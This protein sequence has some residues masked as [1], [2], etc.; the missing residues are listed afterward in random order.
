VGFAS[1]REKGGVAALR[2][3]LSRCEDAGALNGD[4]LALRDEAGALNGRPSERMSRFALGARDG[5]DRTRTGKEMET[6]D[7]DALGLETQQKSVLTSAPS[8]SEE[9]LRVMRALTFLGLTQ[10]SN[11]HVEAQRCGLLQRWDSSME[12]VIF[13]SQEWSS[14]DQPDHTGARLKCMQ[15][16]IRRMLA[17]T[18]PDVEPVLQDRFYLEG[19]G[20]S[21]K[22]WKH[23]AHR[24][25]ILSDCFSMR[26][27]TASAYELAARASTHLFIVCPPSVR[28]RDD[29]HSCDLASWLAQSWS[30]FQM[31]MV[32]VHHLERVPVVVVRGWHQHP[33]PFLL[34]AHRCESL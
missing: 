24:A 8:C 2:V 6:I 18:Y 11:S 34:G 22:R 13:V 33:S 27:S 16:V 7:G 32:R 29:G 3:P 31:L 9:K 10:E 19:K 12:V 5:N 23:L 17:G 14:Y 1:E 4:C 26:Q 20:I 15:Q 25:H 21:S 28:H 30:R